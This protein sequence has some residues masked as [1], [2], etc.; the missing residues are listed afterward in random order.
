M[1]FLFYLFLLGKS[2]EG[3]TTVKLN[4]FAP[5]G[6]K[7]IGD[8]TFWYWKKSDIPAATDEAGEVRDDPQQCYLSQ[9]RH[10]ASTQVFI[11]PFVSGSAQASNVN[12]RY[13][14]DSN[15]N[16]IYYYNQYQQALTDQQ[17]PVPDGERDLCSNTIRSRF[18]HTT[19]SPNTQ[20]I[21]ICPMYRN[22]QTCCLSSAQVY[23]STT[24]ELSHTAISEAQ[25]LRKSVLYPKCDDLIRPFFCIMCHPNKKYMTTEVFAEETQTDNAE[26]YYDVRVCH[27]FAQKLY[28][29]CRYATSVSNVNYGYGWVVEPGMGYNDFLKKLHI[30]F[31]NNESEPETVDEPGVNC[32]DYSAGFISSRASTLLFAFVAIVSFVYAFF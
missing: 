30:D 19:N 11:L 5:T 1:M 23:A 26:T 28:K 29:E 4:T 15:N 14:K 22:H 10:C 25:N 6:T 17:R 21:N 32:W 8:N 16:R 20:L 18:T 27:S 2:A 13:F 24:G 31:L 9:E 3:D 7:K 12:G